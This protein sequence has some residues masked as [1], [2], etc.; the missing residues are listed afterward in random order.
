MERLQKALAK[1]RDLRENESVKSAAGRSPSSTS[2]QGGV[3]EEIAYQ[4]TRTV[5]ISHDELRSAGVV[6]GLENDPLS[7]VFKI[8]RTKVMQ[9]MRALNLNTLAITSPTPGCGKSLIASNLAVSIALDVNYSVLLVDLDLR[10]PALHRYFGLSPEVGLSDYLMGDIPL[11][12]TLINPGINHLVL[13]NGGTKGLSHSSEL[14]AMP[15]MKS[16]LAD[17]KKRYANRIIIFDLPPLLVTDDA[18]AFIPRVDSCLLVVEEGL[19]KP[20][21]VRQSLHLL[22]NCEV[23]GTILNKSADTQMQQ[24]YYYKV[25]TD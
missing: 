24:D 17:M 7:D 10:R 16:L 21:Q 13:L 25:E 9:R 15:K 5:K 22:E 6:A 2:V 8:L 1:A 14:L 4:E 11:S 20:D 23:L 12:E 18:L 19:T 3:A